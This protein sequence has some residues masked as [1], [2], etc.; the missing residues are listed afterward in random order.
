[1]ANKYLHVGFNWVGTP[2]TN[3]LESV[4]YACGSDWLRYS[5]SGWIVYTAYSISEVVDIIKPHIGPNDHMIIFEV[6]SLGQSNGW[7]P[8]W[9]WDWVNK[10]RY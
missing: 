8:K 7:M 10:V 9:V 3:D 2:K 4:F 5:I 1:M 6:T